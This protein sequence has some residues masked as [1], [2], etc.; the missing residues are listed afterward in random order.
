[1]TA[2]DIER[3]LT[4]F[5]PD[6]KS[7]AMAFYRDQLNRMTIGDLERMA[8]GAGF[9]VLAIVPRTRTEDLMELTEDILT[10]TRGVYPR[11]EVNDLVCRVVR[12]ALRRP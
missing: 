6:E 9:E 4:R 2:A 10:Q 8:R 3:Y 5:R 7:R 12:V 11:V 1:L